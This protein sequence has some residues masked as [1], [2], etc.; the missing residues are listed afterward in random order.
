VV[1]GVEA[2]SVGERAIDVARRATGAD[3]DLPARA[4]L[5][6]RLDRAGHYVL[7]ELG[8]TAEPGWVAA[9]ALTDRDSGSGPELELITWARNPSGEP[10]VHPGP[11]ELVWRPS[12]TAASPLYPLRR[13]SGTAGG[14]LVDVTGREVMLDGSGRG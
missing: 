12:T 11:G 5:V 13:M 3:P 4:E 1:D 7:V 2:E 9:V 8:R 14:R 6:R 10:T